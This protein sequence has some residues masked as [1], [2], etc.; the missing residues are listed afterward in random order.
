MPAIT[1]NFELGDAAERNNIP[2]VGI[3]YKDLLPDHVSPGGYIINLDDHD[4]NG[5]TH[6]TGAWVE[7]DK[8][9][10]DMDLVYFDPF[11]FAPPENVKKFFRGI[12]KN[13][14]YSRTHVQ[15]INSFICGYYVLY[16]LW[17]MTHR[18]GSIYLKFK[19]FQRLWSNDPE[20]NRA[21]LAE[22]IK[23]LD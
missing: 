6:W 23:V 10:P 15:N 19:Q 12:D 21:L 8:V 5:G 18:P 22:Y 2:L 16:F 9:G 3:F 4:G 7:K 1:S 17:W 20:D 14:T 11:G 13:I